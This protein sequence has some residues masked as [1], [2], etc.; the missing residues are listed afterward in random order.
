MK[1]EH[2][3]AVSA[4]TFAAAVHSTLS[5]SASQSIR[6]EMWSRS[7]ALFVALS[8]LG[9][10]MANVDDFNVTCKDESGQNVD[11]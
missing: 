6:F 2:Q 4:G 9:N 10:C 7:V 11:W 3:S 8:A 5:E 1:E